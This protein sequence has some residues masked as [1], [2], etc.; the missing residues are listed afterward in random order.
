MGFAVR[1][2]HRRVTSQ[3]RGG[4]EGE[5]AAAP[6]S[7]P[8]GGTCG[9]LG[10]PAAGVWDPLPGYHGG[11]WYL[12][13]PQGC[14]LPCSW[15][16]VPSKRVCQR[17]TLPRQGR[18]SEAFPPSLAGTS[19]QAACGSRESHVSSLLCLLVSC[20]QCMSGAARLTAGPVSKSWLQE[21]SCL[22]SWTH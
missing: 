10:G 5:D 14:L 11:A 16:T 12:R 22:P 17:E 7:G 2:G 20:G 3:I 13:S 18:C 6:G 9:G 8:A 21:A 15:G 4:N 1:A 19:P